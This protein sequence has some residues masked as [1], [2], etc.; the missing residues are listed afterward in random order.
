MEHPF[1]VVETGHTY[2]YT[3][4]VRWF[5]TNRLPQRERERER[6]REREKE[7]KRGAVADFSGG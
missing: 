7:R 6:K 5:E 4:I 2:E 1:V 3:A